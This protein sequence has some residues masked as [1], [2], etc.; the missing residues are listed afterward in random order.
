MS[1]ASVQPYLPQVELNDDVSDS[2]KDKLHVLGVSGTSEVG[3]DLFSVFSFIQ[4]FK[5]TLDVRCRLFV[6]ASAYSK[7]Q[8]E[9]IKRCEL[10][11][12]HNSP[13]FCRKLLH[14]CFCTC[15]FGIADGEWTPIDFLFKQVLFVEEED[16]GGECEPLVIADGVE[17][18][19]AFVHPI[20]EKQQTGHLV[21]TE[22]P[23]P[24]ILPQFA[25]VAT[26]TF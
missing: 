1:R 22:M 16:D 5:L 10:N 21:S 3:V 14:L 13:Y 17:K 15:V 9:F 19:H 20:L 4:V 8:N 7:N 18:L 24:A 23:G 2:V 12:M 11:N 6:R 25:S 26:I